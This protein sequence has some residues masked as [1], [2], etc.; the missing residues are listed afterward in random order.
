VKPEEMVE[1]LISFA[2]RVGIL[3]PHNLQFSICN[4]QFAI[5][6]FFLTD[7]TLHPDPEPELC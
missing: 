6:L 7:H 5:P 1:R 3:S 2:A 4:F